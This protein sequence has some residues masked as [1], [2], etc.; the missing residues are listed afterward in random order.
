MAP[1]SRTG[2]KPRHPGTGHRFA[3]PGDDAV[4]FENEIEETGVVEVVV[5]EPPHPDG[6]RE[7]GRRRAVHE[8]DGDRGPGLATIPLDDR[9]GQGWRVALQE[10]QEGGHQK[11]MKRETRDTRAAMSSEVMGM[12]VCLS[13]FQSGSFGSADISTWN[14]MPSFLSEAR[15]LAMS[16]PSTSSSVS[17]SSRWMAGP[18]S[19]MSTSFSPATTPSA[20]RN[21]SLARWETRGSSE[22]MTTVGWRSATGG[23]V[24]SRGGGCA[25]GPALVE[26]QEPFG[27]VDQVGQHHEAAVGGLLGERPPALLATVRA[28]EELQAAPRQRL[29]PRIVDRRHCV[30]DEVEVDLRPA[31]QRDPAEADGG[32]EVGVIGRRRDH[33]AELSSRQ[34][35][36]AVRV[37]S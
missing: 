4:A 16:S 32:V 13:A 18:A 22:M 6:R 33:E 29:H 2:H 7:R 28:H 3:L 31:V 25:S 14:G 5:G 1:R 35:H 36:H 23:R 8:D 9:R 24:T 10:M 27:A 19:T 11:T 15:Y 12:T 34:V 21:A 20:M 37:P 17:S 26:R 30:V